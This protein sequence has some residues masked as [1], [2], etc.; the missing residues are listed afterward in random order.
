MSSTSRTITTSGARAN[1]SSACAAARASKSSINIFST[2]LPDDEFDTVAGLVM[3]QFGRMPRRGEAVNLGEFE[4]RVARADRRRIDSLRV[5][6]PAKF[7]RVAPN[8]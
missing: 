8:E 2:E 7:E 4:F 6:I 1:G 5:T 3:K